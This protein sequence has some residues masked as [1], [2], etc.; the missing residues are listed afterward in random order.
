MVL[1]WILIL[2]VAVPKVHALLWP[3]FSLH[4]GVQWMFFMREG[5]LIKVLVC[6]TSFCFEFGMREE[7]ILA[8]LLTCKI[9]FSFM[10]V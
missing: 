10:F 3:R 7:V 9:N 1:Q 2:P 8:F 5:K 4:D 6:S